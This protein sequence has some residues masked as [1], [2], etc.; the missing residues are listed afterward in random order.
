M[1]KKVKTRE[2]EFVFHLREILDKFFP[3]PLGFEVEYYIG[4]DKRGTKGLYF[5]LTSNQFGKIY[6]KFGRFKDDNFEIDILEKEVAFVNEVIYDLVLAGVTLMKMEAF[7]TYR[8]HMVE[9]EVGEEP[10]R[11]RVPRRLLFIN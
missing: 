5:N 10:F 1:I 9:K 3:E 4:E 6:S 2:N 8:S 11:N 7:E